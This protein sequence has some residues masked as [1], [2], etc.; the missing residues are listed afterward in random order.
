MLAL[1]QQSENCVGGSCSQLGGGLVGGLPV[2][3][4]NVVPPIGGLP[5]VNDGVM[6]DVN[7]VGGDVT[8]SGTIAE[9]VVEVNDAPLIE[10]VL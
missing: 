5:N 10:D 1:A 8:N 7:A 4:G 3:G 6:S 2:N 9:E